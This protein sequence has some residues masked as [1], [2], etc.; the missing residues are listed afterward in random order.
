MIKCPDSKFLISFIDKLERCG[1]WMQI[2]HRKSQTIRK[3]N[4]MLFYWSRR[5]ITNGISWWPKLNKMI[6]PKEDKVFLL[7]KGLAFKN[8]RNCWS[9]QSAW[10]KVIQYLTQDDLCRQALS[11][12][13]KTLD[14]EE[15]KKS[16]IGSLFRTR[17]PGKKYGRI[18]CGKANGWIKT[19]QPFLK[20][21]FE[22]FNQL[23][24]SCP[25]MNV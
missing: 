16:Q 6:K 25:K 3:S 5:M 4:F 9:Y 20:L 11:F 23:A 12:T 22:K 21:N 2:G 1:N 7:N 18:K 15:L 13:V 8:K 24:A 14:R 17:S 19:K 10:I